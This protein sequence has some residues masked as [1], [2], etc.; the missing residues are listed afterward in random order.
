MK[1]FVFLGGAPGVGKTT[2]VRSLLPALGP[3]A[4]TQFRCGTVRGQ[5]Y[6]STRVLLLGLYAENEVF[7]GTDRLSTALLCDIPALCEKLQH[8]FFEEYTLLA[9]GSRI[10]TRSCIEL[11]STN[12]PGKVTLVELCSEAALLRRKARGNQSESWVKGIQTQINNVFLAY[13]HT[14][15]SYHLRN[16]TPTQLR[17]N[18]ETLLSLL[19]I[20]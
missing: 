15:P 13:Q 10:F 4:S 14:I 9:E 12:F 18:V 11:F 2:T 17:R 16:D 6:P 3:C 1:A 20:S 5:L 7:A 8:P 19:F